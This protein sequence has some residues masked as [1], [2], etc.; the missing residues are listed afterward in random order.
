VTSASFAPDG[1]HVLT[2][3]ADGSVRLWD[4]AVTMVAPVC[5]RPSSNA[6]GT[7]FLV[8]TNDAFQVFDLVSGAPVSS[9]VPVGAS[10][11]KAEL[12][13]DGGFV[14]G[15]LQSEPGRPARLL[16]VWEAAS[17]RSV[18]QGFLLTNP[19]GRVCLSSGGGRLTVCSGDAAR[20]WDVSSAKPLSE[21]LSH[22][23]P[24]G[25]CCFSPDEKH[26]ATVSS[27]IVHVWDAATGRDAFSP[28]VHSVGVSHVAFSPDSSVFVT[29]T[30]DDQFRPCSARVWNT[31]TGQPAG[32]P[33]NH[34]DG[35]LQAN[36]SPDGRLV[37]TASEDFTAVVWETATGL[38]VTPPLPHGHHVYSAVF[39]SDSRWLLTTSPDGTAR[40]W[41][42]ETGE[43]LTP[44]LRHPDMIANGVFLPDNR[45]VVTFGMSRGVWVWD[46]PIDQRPVEDLIV[47]ERL[48]S[49]DKRSSAQDWAR[50]RQQYPA[51]FLASPGETGI[52][53]EWEALADEGRGRWFAAAFHWTQL[54]A[55]RTND[56]SV[57]KH[58]AN[59]QARLGKNN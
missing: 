53:H 39:S 44:S 10:L 30:A 47:L 59:A 43:P 29:S 21:L 51:D 34:G 38:P 52:W 27:N 48:L 17:G 23:K 12:S 37:A 36:F 40:V 4:L 25:F 11:E 28:I 20:I 56:A 57:S 2:A 49:G 31:A 33:L 35:V 26:L 7:R 22:Q 24:V 55:I 41:S 58:L 1:H 5:T 3:A 6:N 32:P 54:S 50:L 19:P 46:L 16:R 8:S 18:G 14:I 45:H 9:P 13:A 15:T 42:V